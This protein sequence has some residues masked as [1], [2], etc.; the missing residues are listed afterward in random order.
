MFQKHPIIAGEM[1]AELSEAMSSMS[2]PKKT[3]NEESTGDHVTEISP[4]P[5]GEVPLRAQNRHIF[6]LRREIFDIYA[7]RTDKEWI[8]YV[9]ENVHILDYVCITGVMYTHPELRKLSK[10]HRHKVFVYV[11]SSS[12][13]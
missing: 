11:I 3:D 9:C 5:A 2:I 13:F 7:S 1:P 4:E 12:P 8:Q 6:Y 10:D